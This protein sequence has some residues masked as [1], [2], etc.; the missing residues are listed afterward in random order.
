MHFALLNLLSRVLF[1]FMLFNFRVLLV[2][3]MTEKIL[4][5]RIFTPKENK[6]W[7]CKNRRYL[8]KLFQY[9]SW[10]S[11]WRVCCRIIENS[12]ERNRHPD[13]IEEEKAEVIGVT[14]R[15]YCSVLK[16]CILTMDANVSSTTLVLTLNYY[17]M[18]SETPIAPYI[19]EGYSDKE[20]QLMVCRSKNILLGSLRTISSIAALNTFRTSNQNIT[21]L[22]C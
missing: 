14:E 8:A 16:Q 15:I 22:H 12:D 10:Q 21:Q 9:E 13:S 5:T 20:K 7:N 2:R 1:H 19:I 17:W 11:S 4:E 18:L 6:K 3:D